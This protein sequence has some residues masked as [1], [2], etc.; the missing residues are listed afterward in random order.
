MNRLT[1][2]ELADVHL[3]YGATGSNALAAQRLY[4]QRF[5][6]RDQ[7]DRSVFV[8]VDRTLRE[9]GSFQVQ[10]E[11]GRLRLARDGLEDAVMARI[12][13]NP[14]KSIRQVASEVGC[15]HG[16]VWN[17]FHDNNLHPF[18]LKKV[19]HLFPDDPPRRLHY[20]QWLNQRIWENPDFLRYVCSTDEKGF[21]R[22][23]MFN[24]HNNHFWSE[25][26]PHVMHVRGYQKKFF[27]NVWAGIV[28]DHLLGPYVLPA[29]L[30][31][32]N[33]LIFLQGQLQ[34]YFEDLPLQIINNMWWQ[35]DGCPRTGQG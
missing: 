12:A 35:H 2:R 34:E 23:G 19:Q 24:A 32:E 15:S 7:V 14:Q 11:R 26:N 29:R 1:F 31:A 18:K 28:G 6:Q 9:T 3:V 25:E 8:N 27:V 17:I 13:D 20:C 30:N 22:E 4:A 21:S 16:T 33:Y 10:Q 5:P